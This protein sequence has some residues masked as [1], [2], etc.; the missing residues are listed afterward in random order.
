MPLD[1]STVL[2]VIRLARLKLPIESVPEA[3]GTQEQLTAGAS[4]EAL[5]TIPATG[6]MKAMVEEFAKIVDYM[7]ILGEAQT[8][9]VEPMYSPMLEPQPPR[10]DEHVTDPDRAE[11]ILGQAPQRVGRYFSVPRIF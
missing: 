9:G 3:S 4:T 6:P 2:A 10:V 7:A 11:A 5:E 1:K 8:A